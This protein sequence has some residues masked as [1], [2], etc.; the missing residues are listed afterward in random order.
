[1]DLVADRK[2]KLQKASNKQTVPQEN[3]I[4]VNGEEI[5][6]KS[7]EKEG[8]KIKFRNYVPRDTTLITKS[9]VSN[10]NEST[11]VNLTNNNIEMKGPTVDVL[12]QE[13]ELHNNKEELNI[14]P[15]K[16]NWDLKSQV[17]DKIEK[18]RNRTIRSIVEILREKIVDDVGGTSDDNEN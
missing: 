1:M 18:L 13:L 2:R 7:D 3:N 16:P 11:V 9:Q 10:D 6:E 12:R 14:V 5:I 15:K 8:K 4:N 17:S